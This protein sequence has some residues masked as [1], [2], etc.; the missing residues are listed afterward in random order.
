MTTSS[1]CHCGYTYNYHHVSREKTILKL[2][3]T[4]A[5]RIDL[6]K[7][8]QR[9][10]HNVLSGGACYNNSV[11]SVTGDEI[12]Q[13][14]VFAHGSGNTDWF[15]FLGG[16]DCLPDL[17]SLWKMWILSDIARSRQA[18]IRMG[19]L[20]HHKHFLLLHS[21]SVSKSSF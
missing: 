11:I 12:L 15:S 21:N 8:E 19:Q 18:E 10:A 1:I 5:E 7:I 3:E 2:S 14:C 4:E 17:S 9:F 16:C 6:T 13:S 20:S